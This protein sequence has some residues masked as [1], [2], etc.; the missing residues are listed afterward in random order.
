MYRSLRPYPL[1]SG[2]L[3]P[4][5]SVV[6]PL[7]EVFLSHSRHELRSLH[8]ALLTGDHAVLLS[9]TSAT[10]VPSIIQSPCIMCALTSPPYWNHCLCCIAQILW[11]HLCIAAFWW[12]WRVRLLVFFKSFTV[13]CD[14]S[15]PLRNHGIFLHSRQ[16]SVAGIPQ[17]PGS[18]VHVLLEDPVFWLLVDT[19]IIMNFTSIITNKNFKVSPYIYRALNLVPLLYPTSCWTTCYPFCI[20]ICT[21]LWNFI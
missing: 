13:P 9:L 1:V 6:T 17:A 10:L 14:I 18:P 15:H 7:I 5:F 19:S 8:P 16:F 3:Y 11:P 12:N 2:L 4:C 21:L 20:L